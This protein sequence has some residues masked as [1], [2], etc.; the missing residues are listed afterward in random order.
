[1]IKIIILL[2]IIPLIAL[3]Q[4]E[5]SKPKST[6][7]YMMT[8]EKNVFHVGVA[9]IG[10]VTTSGQPIMISDTSETNYIKKTDIYTIPTSIYVKSL[11]STGWLISGDMYNDNGKIVI[12]RQ[13]HE[14]T[15][16]SPAVTPNLFITYQSGDSLGW[17]KNEKVCIGNI[18]YYNKKKYKCI[19]E[20]VTEYIPPEVPALWKEIYEEKCP[21]WKQPLGAHDAY[22]KGDCVTFEGKQYESVI[23]ANV[24]S[25]KV[26]PA[27]WKLQEIK[28]IKGLK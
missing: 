28:S 24:W 2:I 1:M 14:R 7:Y 25:P 26:Y 10:Y 9:E 12:V 22:N 5:I 16:Y 6:T 17:I 4:N 13:S 18:R 27:G 15:I 21:E 3:S 8:D 19:Q 23:D 11:P 20:H